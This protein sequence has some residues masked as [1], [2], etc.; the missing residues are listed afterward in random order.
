MYILLRSNNR[1][2]KMRNIL[3]SSALR[4]KNRCIKV[5]K[6]KS[7]KKVNNNCLKSL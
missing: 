5:E 1:L 4:K 7:H 6:Q 3:G 2:F